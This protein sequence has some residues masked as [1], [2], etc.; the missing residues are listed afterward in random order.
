M[1][2]W[3]ALDHA[4]ELQQAPLQLLYNQSCNPRIAGH[5]GQL[6]HSQL[7]GPELG[8]LE[9]HC[10]HCLWGA[11]KLWLLSSGS[12]HGFLLPPPV[13]PER[14][15]SL[16]IQAEVLKTFSNFFELVDE[17]KV[18]QGFTV[19]IDL[20]LVGGSPDRV[21][22]K[23]EVWCRYYFILPPT[24]LC[25]N[26]LLENPHSGIR[27][28]WC[29]DPWGDLGWCSEVGFCGSLDTNNH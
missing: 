11:R 29:Q 18:T 26:E 22:E 2:R 21:C 6:F 17:G 13:C 15:N 20:F 7:E 8:L 25:H 4:T 12:S 5:S 27:Q 19:R 10:L 23:L 1:T 16:W 14:Q 9:G 24:D 28:D 3:P